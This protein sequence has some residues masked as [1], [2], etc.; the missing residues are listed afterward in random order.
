[1]HQ[2]NWS[3]IIVFHISGTSCVSSPT[4]SP[5]PD[6]I[7]LVLIK[8]CSLPP[9]DTLDR[10]HS[11]FSSREQEWMLLLGV[12]NKMFTLQVELPEDNKCKQHVPLWTSVGHLC[13]WGRLRCY[14]YCGEHTHFRDFVAFWHLFQWEGGKA[15][16]WYGA[17]VRNN[18]DRPWEKNVKSN[19]NSKTVLEGHSEAAP[20]ADWAIFNVQTMCK[21][22]FGSQGMILEGFQ[23]KNLM[24]LET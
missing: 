2:I 19:N 14:C 3:I 15:K 20:T 11:T 18:F 17:F 12:S 10:R 4:Y 6:I 23:T 13:L 9:S 1:M 21:T 24:A 7:V 16:F 8:Q 22:R 5:D